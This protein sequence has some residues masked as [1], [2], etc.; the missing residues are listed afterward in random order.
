MS[1]PQQLARFLSANPFFAS[2]G[3]SALQ[4]VARLCV[5]RSLAAREVLF[6]KND[7]ADALYAV[8]RGAIRIATGTAEGRQLTLNMLG[9]GDVFG[10]VALFD[11]CPRT[12]DA[13]AS[14]PTELFV[15]RRRDMLGLL[16]QQPSIAIAIIELLCKR[17]RWMSE[18]MEETTFLP[19]PA[20]LGRR[21][22]ALADD[23]GDDI[24]ITQ[25]ELAV[26]ANTSR[27]TI[28]RQ[29][30]AWKRDGLVAL[31][32]SRVRLLDRAALDAIAGTGGDAE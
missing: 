29:L 3:E 30:Q 12:A 26:F 21:L 19:V 13:I 4:A 18:R 2:L 28:N 16:T 15:I 24:Q 9:P 6:Q 11:G 32:R 20:R 1:D 25:E 5:T 27:E 17:V 8:R 14:E 23:Y 31:G 7:P 22:V 10:E